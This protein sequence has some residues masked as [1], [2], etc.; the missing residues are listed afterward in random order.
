MSNTLEQNIRALLS[1]HT[2]KQEIKTVLESLANEYYGKKHVETYR[3]TLES[4]VSPNV[5]AL[6]DLI[7]NP[8]LK[9][10][11]YG[12]CLFKFNLGDR[13][14]F[15]IIQS[16]DMGC[17]YGHN[18]KVTIDGEQHKFNTKT[19]QNKELQDEYVNKLMTILSLNSADK[20]SFK[21]FL[22]NFGAM[23]QYTDDDCDSC[24]SE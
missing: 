6:F 23:G 9:Y 24:C 3:E 7:T 21:L 17:G 11:Q 14:H 15:N 18:F 16:A 8:T 12:E 22:F 4:E 1:S 5:Y 10:D 19:L 13:L 20:N 2:N